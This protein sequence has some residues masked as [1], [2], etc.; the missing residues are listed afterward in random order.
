MQHFYDFFRNTDS[1]HADGLL[2]RIRDDNIGCFII[3]L[4]AGLQP[5]TGNII[6]MVCLDGAHTFRYNS[7]ESEPISIKAGALRVYSRGL[8]G[9]RIFWARSARSQ[10]LQNQAKYCFLFNKQHTIFGRPFT[11]LVWPHR[12]ET[13]PGEVKGLAD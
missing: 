12:Y 9:C 2:L 8:A 3:R 7:A 5:N 4:E 13:P 11:H 1:V 6:Y 10:Q